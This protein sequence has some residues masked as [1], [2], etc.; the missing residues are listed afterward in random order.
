V[1][2]LTLT[3]F[4]SEQQNTQLRFVRPR[5]MQKVHIAKVFIHIEVIEDLM[6]YHFPREELVADGKVP[7][8]DFSWQSGRPDGELEDDEDEPPS[9]YCVPDFEPRGFHR[10]GDDDDNREHRHSRARGIMHQVSS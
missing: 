8:R 5:G 2:F 6:F 1:V 3:Q 4:E 7:W 9:S 10:D